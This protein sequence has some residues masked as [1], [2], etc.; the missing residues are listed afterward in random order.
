VHLINGLADC[1]IY[2]TLDGGGKTK[3]LANEMHIYEAI[4]A[5]NY[6]N[7]QIGTSD[8]DE[9]CKTKNVPTN[10]LHIEAE[11]QVVS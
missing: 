6:S 2:A 1:P 10:Q 11:N 7:V 4:A 5:R 9:G 8:Q 3:I